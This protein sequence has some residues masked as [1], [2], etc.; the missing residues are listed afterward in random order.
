M[1]IRD[2]FYQRQ[3]RG[4]SRFFFASQRVARKYWIN[5]A[6][7]VKNLAR[8]YRDRL[9]SLDVNFLIERER[10]EVRSLSGVMD[11]IVNQLKGIR[12]LDDARIDTICVY[13]SLLE[14]IS[15]RIKSY[16]GKDDFS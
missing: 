10:K 2:Y 16:L 14:D 13:R 3:I 4:K 6:R 11:G 12:P 8:S 1:E 9:N 15:G 5:Q 7:A